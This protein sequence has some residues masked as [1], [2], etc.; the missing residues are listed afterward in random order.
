[1][2][3]QEENSLKIMAGNNLS[4]LSENIGQSFMDLSRG[5]DPG[6]LQRDRRLIP[7]FVLLCQQELDID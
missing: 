3:Q 5:L 7:N 1:M 4:R 2:T 6:I